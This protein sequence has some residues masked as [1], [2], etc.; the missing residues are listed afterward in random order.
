[1]RLLARPLTAS[2]TADLHNPI[3]PNPNTTPAKNM[4]RNARPKSSA[5]RKVTKRRDS[6]T[7]TSSSSLDLS[8]DGGYSAVEDI[9]DSDD[10]DEEDV[11]AVEEEHIITRVVSNNRPNG[12]PRPDQTEVAQEQEQEQDADSEDTDDDDLEAETADADIDDDGSWD[13]IVSEVDENVSSDNHA[14]PH[15]AAHERHV[16]FANV[17][18]SDSDS[19]DTDDDHADFFPDLFVDQNTLDPAF[20]RELELDDDDASSTASGTFWD[21]HGVYEYNASD[22]AEVE[23]IIQELENDNTPVVGLS[24]FPLQDAAEVVPGTNLET[25]EEDVQELDGYESE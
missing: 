4:P 16:R 1:M 24:P 14:T 25:V 8:D 9:T 13:G 17:P 6:D 3:T 21:F 11:D 15:R 19:T 23:A 5:S 2:Y 20:R 18:S 7:S 22:D 10:D 12:S